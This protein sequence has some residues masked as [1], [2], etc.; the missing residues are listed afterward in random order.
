[1]Q[2][3]KQRG[4]EKSP[5]QEQVAVGR[6]MGRD[7]RELSSCGVG[8]AYPHTDSGREK[9]NDLLVSEL[10]PISLNFALR[11]KTQ[12]RIEVLGMR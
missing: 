4:S 12:R 7:R 2:G 8:R 5:A 1:M 3:N 9:G 11:S 10:L 6:E